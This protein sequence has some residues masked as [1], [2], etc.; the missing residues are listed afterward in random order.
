MG[1][2]HQQLG[3]VWIG[4]ATCLVHIGSKV[5]KLCSGIHMFTALSVSG[6]F[7]LVSDL[8]YRRRR[9]FECISG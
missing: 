5:A 6:L 7:V 8:R 3:L 1:Y 4:T 9:L 2:S